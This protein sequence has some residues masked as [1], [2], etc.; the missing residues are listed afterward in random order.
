[1]DKQNTSSI[2]LGK[3]TFKNI[4]ESRISAEIYTGT[5]SLAQFQQKKTSQGRLGFNVNL[6]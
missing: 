2:S 4:Q 1:M 6:L 3:K 5:F